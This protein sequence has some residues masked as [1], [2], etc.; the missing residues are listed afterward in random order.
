MDLPPEIES[1]NKE[2]KLKITTI[3]DERID[4]L[5]SQL[6]WRLSEGNGF[7]EYY[8]GVADDGSIKG[9]EIKDYIKTI[10]NLSK[11]TKIIDAKVISNKKIETKNT[12]YYKIIITSEINESISSRVI[13]IGPNNS[14]KSTIIGN[15]YKNIAD[16]GDGKSRT[17]V[18]NHKHEIYSGETSSI[19]IQNIKLKLKKNKLN[20]SLIDTPGKDSYKKTMLTC[21]N[22]YLPNLIFL[23]IDPLE[24]NINKLKF[25]L[26]LLK[27]YRYP[28]YIL[29]TKK[30]KYTNLHKNYLLK[31]ILQICDKDYN[32]INIKKVPFIEIDNIKK[33]GY[34]KL[35]KVIK[36]YTNNNNNFDG[37]LQ[38][39]DILNI[40]NFPKI[41][42]G[43]TFNNININNK[44][45]II[46]SNMQQVV[47]INTIYYLDNPVNKIKKNNLITF[48]LKNDIDIDNKTGLLLI[49]NPIRKYKELKIKSKEI[50]SSNQGICFYNNQYHIIQI[51]H[52]NDDIYKIIP[53]DKSYFINLS[54]KIIIRIN[55]NFYFTGLIY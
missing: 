36:K 43:L 34:N 27:Y 32:D 54:K 7:A 24:I 4:Q 9:I 16:D 21:I 1:G 55:N 2:Y 39:C 51:A 25:Y 15:L 44:Y 10:Q 50:I 47:E 12:F 8:I 14:G 22:K 52:L 23:V 13:F 33:I 28:F 17:F 35:K 41:Y 26:N 31:N 38:V 40:P 30:D 29:F 3:F 42:V 46:S 45:T 48:T 53:L 18:F 37:I 49:D 19:S 11:I 20:V 6:K 5:A